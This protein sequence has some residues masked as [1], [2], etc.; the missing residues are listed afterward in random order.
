[1]KILMINVVCGIRSTG[2]ICTDLATALENQGY[3]VKIAYGRENVPKQYQKY[4]VRI[5]NDFDVK[6]HGIKARL[7]DKCGFGSKIATV[8]FIRW[9]KEYDPDVIHL[10]NLHGYYINIKILFAYLKTCGK[11]IIWTLHDCWAFTGHSAY[12]DAAK[13]E[14]WRE[15]CYNCPQIHEYPKS[16]IDMSKTNWQKKRAIITSI[17]SMKIVTPS[18]W[19][20]GL[21]KQSFLKKYDLEVIYNG[22][23]TSQFYPMENDFREAYGLQN[24][25][26]LLGMF[27]TWDNMKELSDY[28][29]L[30]EL[31]S[32]EYK[33][34]LVGLTDHQIEALPKNILGIKRTVSTKE[35]AYIYSSVDLLLN[36]SKGDNRTINADLLIYRT[37]V[38]TYN[39]DDNTEIV[40]KYG[41]SVLKLENLD[42]VIEKICEYKQNLLQTN[43]NSKVD[44]YVDNGYMHHFSEKYWSKKSDINL[45]GKF[46]LLGVAAI[47]DKRKGLNDLIA[48]SKIL[49]NDY[50]I[51]LVGLTEE[52]LKNLPENIIGFVRTNSVEEL[53]GLY[54]IA[55][56]LINPTYEDNFPTTN[57]E[58][59]C[60][61]T[62]V[63]TYE[64][65]GS[66]ES[67]GAC[68]GVI[69]KGDLY[70]IVKMITKTSHFEKNC[71]E[72]GNYF[73]KRK[74]TNNYIILYTY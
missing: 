58:A 14:K 11:K 29:Q 60:C 40:E 47:W 7:F 16:F 25:F 68:G 57:I 54:A 12:C 32:S 51:I 50:Q 13:C 28:L 52:Q 17:P 3:E 45:L 30:S 1:M 65:G 20:A 53:R 19:L 49:P 22:I 39:T 2:R 35:L 61:G 18:K 73:D 36:L 67:V 55:D 24:K 69:K 6:I 72:R 5:G 62:P 64:T 21:V 48:L 70:S 15:G 9:V 23:D 38:L 63:I 8:R 34:V 66:P 41:G 46:V 31:L 37:P 44:Y 43:L 56:A 33:I 10:H 4:A 71:V 26:I 59:L 27:T 42:D 74:M